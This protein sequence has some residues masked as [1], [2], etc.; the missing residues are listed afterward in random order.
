M[1]VLYLQYGDTVLES[2][3]RLQKTDSL[4]YILF[5]IILYVGDKALRVFNL[6]LLLAKGR[7][8]VEYLKLLQITLIS[9]FFGF[10]FPG[11]A[12]P[13]IARILHLKKHTDGM[14]SPMSATLWLNIATIQ[15]AALLS[16]I[17]AVSMMITNSPINTTLMQTVAVF[18]LAV[19]S[20]VLFF[21]HHSVQR[22]F[23]YYFEDRLLRNWVFIRRLTGKLLN[24][25][26]SQAGAGVFTQTILISLLVLLLAGVRTYCLSKALALDV[27]LI[28]YIIIMPIIL[29]ILIIPVSFAGIGVREYSFVFFLGMVGVQESSAF[30]LGLTVTMLNVLFSVFGGV[31]YLFSLG[32]ADNKNTDSGRE[33]K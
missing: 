30:A 25:F 2:L 27:D 10:F 1:V 17:G 18:S 7:V 4:L 21:L 15:A 5:A 13:D 31:L 23:R 26:E 11:G 8:V 29:F 6:K 22:V 9:A 33:Q 12:G 28:F 20:S 3:Q 14:A 24:A 19:F 32:R 16:F